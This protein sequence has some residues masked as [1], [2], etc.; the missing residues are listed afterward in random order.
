MVTAAQLRHLRP[1]EAVHFPASDPEWEM[2]ESVR[3]GQLCD[4]L[5]YVL[6]HALGEEHTAGHDQFVYFDAGDPR[7]K[8][9]PDVFVKL[10]VAP[11]AFDSWKTW[12]QGTPEL[13]VEILSPSDTKEK[14]GWEQKMKRYRAIGVAEVVSFDLDAPSGTRLRVWDR[15][16]GDLVERLVENETTPCLTLGAYWVIVPSRGLATAEYPAALRLARDP[17]GR[18]LL[19]TREEAVLAGAQAEIERLRAEL[20]AARR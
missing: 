8:C 7:R 5:Y 4:L 2:G 3:H 6:T 16:D 10:G 12:E 17:A 19:P 20:A 13:C 9:A 15:I 1:V 14:L 18:E 11:V